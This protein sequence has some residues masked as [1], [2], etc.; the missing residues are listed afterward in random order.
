MPNEYD[1]DHAADEQDEPPELTDDDLA[2]DI[3]EEPF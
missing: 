3:D 1:P 2:G